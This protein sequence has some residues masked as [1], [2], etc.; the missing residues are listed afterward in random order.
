MNKTSLNILKTSTFFEEISVQE[1][2][3]NDFVYI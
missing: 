1:Y 2:N 3:V